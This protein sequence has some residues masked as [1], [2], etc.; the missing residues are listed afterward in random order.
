MRRSTTVSPIPAACG[1]SSNADVSN[2]IKLRIVGRLGE[3]ATPEVRTYLS[4]L[5]AAL[6]DAGGE[7]GR[8][9]QDAMSRISE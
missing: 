9:I 7:L 1:K 3:L 4:D 5:S 8:A 2:A 6:P